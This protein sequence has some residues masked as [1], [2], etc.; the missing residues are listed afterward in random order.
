MSMSACVTLNNGAR[1]VRAEE[2]P[3]LVEFFGF[4]FVSVRCGHGAVNTEAVDDEVDFA[5]RERDQFCLFV[6]AT[7]LKSTETE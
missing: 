5:L 1:P 4:I 7:C 6:H 2:A 3:E